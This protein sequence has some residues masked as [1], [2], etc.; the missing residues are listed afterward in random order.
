MWE[1][2]RSTPNTH[3]PVC[4]GH[5]IVY[6]DDIMVLST[7]EI[8]ASFFERL[9]QEWKCANVETVNQTEWLRFCGFELK[10][11][12]DQ[13]SLMVGQRS[14]TAELLK[15]HSDV[16]PKL[17]PMPRVEGTEGEDEVPTQSEIKA[18]QGITGE[19]LWLSGR[20]RVDISYGVSIMSRNALKKP[21][22]TQLIGRHILGFLKNTPELCLV[23][24]KCD[25]NHGPYGTLQ[26]PRH[27]RL[28]EAFADIS[29]NPQGE[30]S[31]QGVIVCMGGSPVQ[32]EATR[33]A[34]HTHYFCPI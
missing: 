26:I 16:T 9:G 27:E 17:F 6:V 13:T 8:R 23:Y 28:I 22:W 30:R 14:Y 31:H 2:L 15:R 20:S 3:E 19:L 5:I 34:F 25:G 10:R 4:V 1:I 29:F 12:A 24:S 33:Q 32:W 21:R 11:H 18:A 7:D